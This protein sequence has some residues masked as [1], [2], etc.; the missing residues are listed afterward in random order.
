MLGVPCCG[1][2]GEIGLVGVLLV[3][4]GLLLGHSQIPQ[5]VSLCLRSVHSSAL[6]E[7]CGLVLDVVSRELIECGPAPVR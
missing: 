5:L 1:C 2:E 4:V 7:C 3:E 6:L